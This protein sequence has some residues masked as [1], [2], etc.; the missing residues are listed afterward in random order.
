[1][2][3]V[4]QDENQQRWQVSVDQYG[5]L[6]ETQVAQGPVSLIVLQAVNQSN[7]QLVVSTAGAVSPVAYPD[8]RARGAGWVI[9]TTPDQV[10]QYRLAVLIPPSGIPQL[11]TTL[12]PSWSAGTPRGALLQTNDA[13]PP[14]LQPGG[15]G[16]ATFPQQ[17]IGEKLGMW[18]ASCGHFFNS[19]RVI[20]QAFLGIYSAY[21][22]CPVCGFV[23]RIVTPQ[24]LI[25][26]DAF[27]IIIA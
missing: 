14:F 6:M 17:Q 7:W 4:L 10:F 27:F 21:I 12:D 18:V 24:S 15:I 8:R 1:V 2:N 3:F 22:S 19:W 23:Q 16:T 11:T 9:V 5:N 20:S 25:H 26:T 13:Y